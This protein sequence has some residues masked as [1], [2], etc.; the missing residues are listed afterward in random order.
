M[1]RQN[2]LLQRDWKKKRPCRKKLIYFSYQFDIFDENKK[3]K[4]FIEFM[5]NTHCR[6]KTDYCEETGRKSDHVGRN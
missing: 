4:E 1:S 6:G 3:M 5:K 2:R